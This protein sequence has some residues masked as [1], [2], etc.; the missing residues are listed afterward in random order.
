VGSTTPSYKIRFTVTIKFRFQSI[1]MPIRIRILSDFFILSRVPIFSL[2]SWVFL[3]RV[4]YTQPNFYQCFV[5]F[6]KSVNISESAKLGSG[7]RSSSR[8]SSSAKLTGSYCMYSILFSVMGQAIILLFRIPLLALLW[9]RILF[10]KIHKL[11]FIFQ[12]RY[13]TDVGA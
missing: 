5:N 10:N 12:V 2:H 1:L 7:P 13:L 9:I 11:S 4:S 8:R 6:I 3:T